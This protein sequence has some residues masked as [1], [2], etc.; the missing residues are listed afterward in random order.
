MFLVPGENDIDNKIIEGLERISEIFRIQ[1]W[2][3]SLKYQLNPTQSLILLSLHK[4]QALT[5]KDLQNIISL[6]KTTISKSLKSLEQ[7]KFIEK[8]IY[9]GDQRFRTIRLTYKGKKIA[10]QLTLFYQIFL[11]IIKEIPTEKK[12]IYEFIYNFILNAYNKKLIDNQKM[13][14]NCKFFTINKSQNYCNYL[15]KTLQIFELQIDCKDFKEK[16]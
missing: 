1:L 9:P 3:E 12:I 16:N 10:N 13:C 2:R 5:Q 15:K 4:H 8:I 6:D 14:F 11:P 7:K